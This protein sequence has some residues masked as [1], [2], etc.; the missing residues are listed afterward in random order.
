MCTSIPGVGVGGGGGGGGKGGCRGGG[1]KCH[2][3]DWVCSLSLGVNQGFLSHI[4]VSCSGLNAICYC[5]ILS[6]LL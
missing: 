6:F 1:G 3:K 4:Y 5:I 2:I